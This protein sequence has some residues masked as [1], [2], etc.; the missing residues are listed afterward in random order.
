MVSKKTIE[1]KRRKIAP[2][3]FSRKQEEQS[4]T[5]PIRPSLWAFHLLTHSRSIPGKR[6]TI[7]M[8][9]SSHFGALIDK[10]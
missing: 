2:C 3:L 8:L 1:I 4:Q 7:Y 5:K 10:F 6:T 9:C